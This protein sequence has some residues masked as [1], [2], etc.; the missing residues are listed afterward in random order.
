MK[1]SLFLFFT[2]AFTFVITATPV[3]AC[4]KLLAKAERYTTLKRRGGNAKQMNKWTAQRRLYAE[5][6][7]EC[8]RA[9]PRIHSASGNPQQPR[10]KVDRQALR[11]SKSDNP[12]TQKLLTTCNFWIKTYNR[13]PTADN[14]SQRDGACRALDDAEQSPPAIAST[15]NFKRSVKEC[16]KPGNLLDDEVRECM[17]GEREPDWQ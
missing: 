15:P 17:A 11:S 4:E 6:Y 9:Q 8:L 13:Q 10:V 7:Y 2:L 1:G 5:R 12:I 3:Y 16:I 14:K